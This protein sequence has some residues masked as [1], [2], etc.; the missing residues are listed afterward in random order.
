[1]KRSAG[2]GV[3]EEG[4]W[5]RNARR[6]SVEKRIAGRRNAGRG[7]LEMECMLRL[8]GGGLQGGR[9]QEGTAGKEG[10]CGED[11]WKGNCKPL[12]YASRVIGG[13]SAGRRIAGRRSAA[14][15]LR[16]GRVIGKKIAGTGIT[17]HRTQAGIGVLHKEC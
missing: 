10:C 4:C 8:L 15:R 7:V 13:R 5:K 12:A 3:L 6:R 2:R 17:T 1:M 14:G 11:Y 9:V 16:G